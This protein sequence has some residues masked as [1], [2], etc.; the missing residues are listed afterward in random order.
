MLATVRDD[1][2]NVLNMQPITPNSENGI[3]QTSPV[4]AM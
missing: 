4:V 1:T 2:S 3:I